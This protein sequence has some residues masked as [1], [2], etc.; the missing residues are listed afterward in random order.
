MQVTPLLP[1]LNLSTLPTAASALSGRT[2]ELPSP[3]DLGATTD[4]A[5][6]REALQR[7]GQNANS[8]RT[9]S[10]GDTG[11]RSDA[12]PASDAKAPP[13]SET[14]TTTATTSAATGDTTSANETEA[15]EA[16]DTSEGEESEVDLALMSLLAASNSLPAELLELATALPT[17][18][19]ITLTLTEP[20]LPELLPEEISDLAPPLLQQ[21]AAVDF[22]ELLPTEQLPNETEMTTVVAEN[23]VVAAEPEA[24]PVESEPKPEIASPATQRLFTKAALQSNSEP[25]QL[26]EAP[27][28]LSDIVAPEPVTA[29]ITPE[30]AEEKSELPSLG[31]ELSTKSEPIRFDREPLPYNFSQAITEQQELI[32]PAFRPAIPVATANPVAQIDLW[33]R[34]LSGTGLYLRE[35]EVTSMQLELYP[36]S[37]GR[38]TLKLEMESGEL[39]AYFATQSQIVKQALESQMGELHDLLTQQGLAVTELSVQ[40]GNNGQE[41]AQFGSDFGFNQVQPAN[42]DTLPGELTAAPLVQRA[43]DL[44]N[45]LMGGRLYLRI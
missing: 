29:S 5:S 7:A 17:D 4:K 20:L 6:F 22:A 3:A 43:G 24:V 41:K 31:K 23:L 9:A 30:L 36:R 15:V 42:N 35:G 44:W 39:R 28:P 25:E 11:N 27:E 1:E 19:T 34:D 16:V 18:D 32:V 21:D 38:L 2:S 37:L 14:T 40:V 13:V 8:K 10:V 26:F 45:S 33:L 12:E